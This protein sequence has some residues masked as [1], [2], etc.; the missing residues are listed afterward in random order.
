MVH[1]LKL[2]YAYG[3]LPP[4]TLR[5]QAT[6]ARSGEACWTS[7]GFHRSSMYFM[8]M[9]GLDSTGAGRFG[10]VQSRRCM[11]CHTVPRRPLNPP[12]LACV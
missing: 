1:G 10:I 5:A 11:C 2:P 4:R 3:G 6:R 7:R 9:G 12:R 8:R